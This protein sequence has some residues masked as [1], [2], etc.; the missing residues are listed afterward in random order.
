MLRGA[1]TANSELF[2]GE[3][4]IVKIL[5]VNDYCYYRKV[6]RKIFDFGCR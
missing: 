1:G 5:Y 6:K 3:K 4:V 2:M